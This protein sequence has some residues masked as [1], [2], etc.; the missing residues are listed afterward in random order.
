MQ[1]SVIALVSVAGLLTFVGVAGEAMG[2]PVFGTLALA[3]A[4]F[5]G[6]LASAGIHTKERQ[7]RLEVGQPDLFLARNASRSES[8][9][10]DGKLAGW[11]GMR[12]ELARRAFGHPL[13]VADTVKIKSLPEIR[14]TLDADGC[15]DGLP[16]MDEMAAFCGE[17]ARVYRVVDKIYDYGR[18]RR[19]RRL[20]DCVLLSGL[21]CDGGAHGGCEAACYLIWKANW[22]D[23]GGPCMERFPSSRPNRAVQ[24]DSSGQRYSCQYTQLE[25]ASSPLKR[26]GLHGLLG[27]LVVGNVTLSAFWLAVL[28]R[29]FNNVQSRRGGC[30]FPCMPAPGSEALPASEPPRAGTWV[31]IKLP[32][33]I[34]RTLDCASKSRG[35][36]FDKD[37]LKYC[38][39]EFRVRGQIRKIIDVRSGAMISMKTPC[40]VLEEVHYTGEFQTF[41]EQ[42]EY[43]YWREGWLKI[44]DRCSR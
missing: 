29:I 19:M 16:F 30:S 43:L 3:A 13:M 11:I 7:R 9:V 27:P 39:Q 35:L 21:R 24:P 28:T 26:I 40:V 6:M 10:Q 8:S 37:M 36:W 34:A 4:V 1:K 31:R 33:E 17:T 42:H 2:E 23:K 18:S 41:G 20:D 15:L 44:I 22:L 38:G 14:K 12:S 25:K 32:H 5:A